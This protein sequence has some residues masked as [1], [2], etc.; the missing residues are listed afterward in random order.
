[1][2]WK[3]SFV[4]RQPLWQTSQLA[5][6]L[7]SMKPRLADSEIAASSP[8]IQRSNGAGPGSM[9]RSYAA[10]AV[11][12]KSMLIGVLGSAALNFSTYCGI[13]RIR[14]SITSTFTGVSVLCIDI[15]PVEIDDL[16]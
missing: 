5:L 12:I 11:A 2:S 15:E 14:A 9:V 7:N 8:A 3:L 6:L 10:I 13:S 1:M 16:T 4:K